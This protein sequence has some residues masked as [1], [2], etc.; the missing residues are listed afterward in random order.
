[1]KILKVLGGIV[2]ALVVIAGGLWIFREQI[3]LNIGRLRAPH[4]EANHPVTWAQGPDQ[5]AQPADQRPPNVV[6][7]LADD[8]GFND[9]TSMAAASPTVWSLPPPSTRLAMTA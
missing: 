1:M 9:I 7:I 5:A 3:M 6:F 4:I 2:V 8:L